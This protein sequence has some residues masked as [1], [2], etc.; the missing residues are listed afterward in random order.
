[1]GIGNIWICSSKSS[2]CWC[3]RLEEECNLQ[4]QV[5]YLAL[6]FRGLEEVVFVLGEDW[7]LSEESQLVQGDG[8]E[9]HWWEV[10]GCLVLGGFWLSGRGDRRGAW[11]FLRQIMLFQNGRCATEEDREFWGHHFH[12]G[13]ASL[14]AATWWD[15]L[16]SI[17][18]LLESEGICR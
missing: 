3:W 10:R 9:V 2:Q 5:G 14:K 17:H 15:Y 6:W 7:C 1:M 12:R 8:G 16:W 18:S 4:D 13:E 11:V